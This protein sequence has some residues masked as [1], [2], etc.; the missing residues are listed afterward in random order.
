MVY[1]Q[2]EAFVPAVA[3]WRGEAISRRLQGGFSE[4]AAMGEVEGTP[5]Q[6]L[7]TAGPGWGQTP[8]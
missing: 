6:G 1:N 7:R 5:G 8:G 3:L 4:G 2:E